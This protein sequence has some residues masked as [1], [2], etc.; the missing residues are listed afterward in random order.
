MQYDRFY[1]SSIDKSESILAGTEAH[2]L[3]NVK[4]LKVGDRVELFDGKGSLAL[5]EIISITKKQ[6]HLRPIKLNSISQPATTKI[7]IASSIAKGDRFDWL[8]SK[9][10]ELGV[11]AIVPVIFE[12]TVKQPKNKNINQRWKTLAIS[13]AKQCKRLFLPHIYEPL[14]LIQ[15]IDIL[16]VDFSAAQIFCGSPQK[17]CDSILKSY[18]FSKDVIAFI[19]PEGGLTDLEN[20]L[21]QKNGCKFVRLNQNILRIETAAI[22][23]ASILTA[24]R[25]R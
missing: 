10:T 9:S 21:L 8:I 12:R 19:G 18:S 1:C 5:S 23:F 22:S 16:Q 14:T 4:R 13:A 11:D 20:D 17:N 7:I 24:I 6:V 2:H 3:V 15:S 25:N